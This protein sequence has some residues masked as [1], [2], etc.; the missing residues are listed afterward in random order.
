MMDDVSGGWLGS[1]SVEEI[2]AEASRLVVLCFF[3]GFI[4]VGPLSCFLLVSVL[5]DCV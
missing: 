2:S 4:V 3:W 5:F 1:L